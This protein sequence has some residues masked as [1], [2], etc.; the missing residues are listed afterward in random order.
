MTQQNGWY[1][2][3]FQIRAQK[4]LEEEHDWI[5]SQTGLLSQGRTLLFFD[6]ANYPLEWVKTVVN[7]FCR[8]LVSGRKSDLGK[9][10]SQMREDDFEVDDGIH[11]YF[12]EAP[13]VTEK[14]SLVCD[15]KRFPE[16]WNLKKIDSSTNS[17]VIKEIQNLYSVSGL[18]PLPG[19][20]IKGET[21]RCTTFVLFDEVKSVMGCATVQ[22]LSEVDNLYSDR[23]NESVMIVGLCLHKNARGMGL[24]SLLNAECLL[25]GI[26]HY[27][28]RYV[29]ELI[30]SGNVASFRMSE[31]CGLVLDKEEGFA[32][33]ADV[34]DFFGT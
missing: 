25:Y 21:E 23:W 26:N 3:P 11:I 2:T 22:D 28:A 8:V 6:A 13:R 32:F 5:A 17:E 33:I 15:E 12:G 16:G 4:T 10:V 9:L 29:Y 7:K 30:E 27:G 20:F 34:S 18:S 19:S 24:S 14:I 1:G 31:R